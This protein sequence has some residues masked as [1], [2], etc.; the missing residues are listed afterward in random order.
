[1]TVISGTKQ[2]VKQIAPLRRDITGEMDRFNRTK[3]HLWW[4]E[5]ICSGRRS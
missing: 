5:R 3:Q 4:K 2:I 1:L